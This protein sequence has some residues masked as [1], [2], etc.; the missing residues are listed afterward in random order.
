MNKTLILLSFIT[1][2]GASIISLNQVFGQEDSD[3]IPSWVKSVAGYWA[4]DGINDI[5]FVEALEFL[6]DS[7]IIQLGNT[8]IMSQSQVDWE[9]K[10]NILLEE[11]KTADTKYADEI[12][13]MNQKEIGLEKTHEERVEEIISE[14]DAEQEKRIKEYQELSTKWDSLWGEYLRLHGLSSQV[15]EMTNLDD[16]R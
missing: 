8:Q 4:E 11:K 2:I 7:N 14:N 5:E 15:R 3:I 6:I 12:Q 10:Y 9:E 13:K 16:F 1:I